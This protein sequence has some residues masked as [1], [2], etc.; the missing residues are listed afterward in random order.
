M[1]RDGDVGALIG[2]A[3]ALHPRLAAAAAEIHRAAGQLPAADLGSGPAGKWSRLEVLEHLT[4]GFM[5]TRRGVERALSAGAP[6]AQ[7]PAIR[8]RLAR[9]LV[10]ELGYFPRVPAPEM[11]RPRGLLRPENAVEEVLHALAAMDAVLLDAERRFGAGTKLL[12]HPYFAGLTAGAWR[13]FHWRHTCH[14][15]RQIR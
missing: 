8:Q 12:D 13:K 1:H 9:C 2:T 11:T 3:G 7:P 6:R 10:V 4:L 14:H 15:M 5:A